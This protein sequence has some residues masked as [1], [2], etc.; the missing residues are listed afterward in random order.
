MS[1]TRLGNVSSASSGPLLAHFIFEFCWKSALL[2]SS[3]TRDIQIGVDDD[4]FI[5]LGYEA[6]ADDE[7]EALWR[8]NYSEPIDSER[9]REE[10][11]K[12]G[13]DCLRLSSRKSVAVRNNQ[14]S[15]SL[16]RFY[17]QSRCRFL[18]W[19]NFWAFHSSR[20]ALTETHKYTVYYC[21]CRK[22]RCSWRATFPATELNTNLS[23]ISSGT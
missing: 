6:E 16:C 7:S 9:A 22:G 23:V 11:T 1:P 8:R 4:G 21:K 13:C 3:G 10:T 17:S 14:L 5:F 19:E 12:K 15:H 18:L 2:H 20:A